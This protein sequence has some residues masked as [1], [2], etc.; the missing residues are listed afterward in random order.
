MVNKVKCIG[1]NDKVPKGWKYLKSW[2]CE[3]LLRTNFKIFKDLE[4]SYNV[5]Y[6]TLINSRKALKVYF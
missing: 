2:D 4:L 1:L 6:Y 5:G 3:K